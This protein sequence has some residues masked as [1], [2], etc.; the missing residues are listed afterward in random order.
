MG[1]EA[2]RT[3]IDDLVKLYQKDYAVNQRK[4]IKEANRWIFK[5]KH[6]PVAQVDRAAVS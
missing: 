2:M 3:R 6:A 5:D 1:I 4:S